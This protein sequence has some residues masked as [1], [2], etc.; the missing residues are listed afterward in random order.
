MMPRARGL[1][2]A[3]AIGAMLIVT[4]ALPAEAQRGLGLGRGK[5]RPPEKKTPQEQPAPGEYRLDGRDAVEAVSRGEGAHALAYY[6]RAA[7]EAE[8]QGNQVRAA[9]AL[10]C[11]SVVQMRLGRYQ[12]A[13]ESAGRAIELFKK[14]SGLS[15]QEQRAWASAYSHL[16]AAYRAVGDVAK[17][18]QA[19]EEGLKYVRTN[20]SAA[21]ARDSRRATS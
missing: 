19:F 15:E 8:Q 6:E 21:A 20:M 16:G 2:Q 17:A 9:R 14:A 18:R 13:I 10:H 7:K 12:K 5:N 11:A 3:L 1:S 4:L